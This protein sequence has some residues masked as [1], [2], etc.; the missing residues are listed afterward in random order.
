[1]NNNQTGMMTPDQYRQ[2]QNARN[3]LN[4][5]AQET[6]YE[7]NIEANPNATHKSKSQSILLINMAFVIILLAGV[8][9][10]FIS[11]FDMDK[12]V[13]FLEVFAYVWAPLVVAV[14]SGRAVKNYVNKKFH[15]PENT[16]QSNI[17]NDQPPV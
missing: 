6:R 5:R 16:P 15:A 14:G 11:V 4:N 7:Y 10:S 13:S 12:F 8:A 2:Q 1:M 3:S 17:T 9:G